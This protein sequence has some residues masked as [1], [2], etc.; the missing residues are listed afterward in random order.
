MQGD[1]S[2]AWGRRLKTILSTVL[3]RGQVACFNRY[4]CYWSDYPSGRI[5][6]ILAIWNAAWA[7]LA[8]PF[9]ALWALL[10][11]IAG[12]A[13]SAISGVI[14]AGIAVIQSIWS[15]AWTVIQTVFSTVWNTIMSI[16]SPIMAGIS[17]IISSTLSAIQAIWNAIWTGI[18]AVLA[19][20]LLVVW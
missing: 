19:G 8:V 9:Q 17:S 20:G 5:Q 12:G 14:S 7:L 13:M 10:Q 1:W 6:F 4:Q 15:A 16:L 2:G 11:Q 3:G 18:Q